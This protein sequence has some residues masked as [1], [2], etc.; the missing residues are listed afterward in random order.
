MDHIIGT[1]NDAS[2]PNSTWNPNPLASHL[3]YNDWYLL[4]NFSVNTT[5]YSGN[6][7]YASK[8]DW[9][10]RGVKCIGHRNTYGINLASVGVIDN[11]SGSDQALFDFSFASACMWSL[12]ANGTSDTSY[13]ASSATVEFHVRS[14]VSKMGRI[15]SLSPSVQ[16]DTGDADVYWRY[17]DFGKFKV[18]FSTGAQLS[19][20]TKW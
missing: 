10:A 9:A 18:D 19:S 12:E 13:G 3:T 16:V 5:S 4:E 20:I 14:D 8:T 6:N 17:V 1:A 11:G 15:Y 7:G 2:Y